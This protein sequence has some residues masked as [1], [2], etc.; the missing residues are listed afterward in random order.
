MIKKKRYSY[1]QA[2]Q[3]M[4]VCAYKAAGELM[5]LLKN[6][7]DISLNDHLQ[8][9][10]RIENESDECRREI[11]MQLAK[12]SKCPI[13]CED[14]VSLSNALD[15]IVDMVEDVSIGLYIYHVTEVNETSLAY[16][17]VILMSCDCI[18]NIL[19]EFEHRKSGDTLLD[20]L[21]RVNTLEER[22]D[23][24]FAQ[25]TRELFIEETNPIE[26]IKWK[27]IYDRMEAAC[28]ACENAAHFIESVAIKHS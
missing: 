20:L 8:K 1:Y 24:L 15:D 16:G 4:T 28:D 23:E 22:G 17:K 11:M 7:G 6:Y 9:M 5:N 27:S 26:V 3:Q 10:H 13:N 19:E 12:E 21:Q 18:R 14:I 2:M 25:S